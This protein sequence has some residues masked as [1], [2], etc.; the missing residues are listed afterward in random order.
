MVFDERPYIVHIHIYTSY[1][2][3]YINVCSALF[4]IFML[5]LLFFFLSISIYSIYIRYT[6]TQIPTV[7]AATLAL[8]RYTHPCGALYVF[9]H[10]FEVKISFS[11]AFRANF[12]FLFEIVHP[13][14][15]K[16]KKIPISIFIFRS[17]I[18]HNVH[19]QHTLETTIRSPIVD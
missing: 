5:L 10:D 15:R 19:A 2:N 8:A 3:H 13:S 11:L 4:P 1:T 12:S 17:K 9:L 16:K 7:V 6:C 18:I 14:D